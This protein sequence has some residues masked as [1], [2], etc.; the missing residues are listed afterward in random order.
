[1]PPPPRPPVLAYPPIT[2]L[3]PTQGYP[4]RNLRIPDPGYVTIRRRLV[5]ERRHLMKL[6]KGDR[7][8]G[9]VRSP[10]PRRERALRE[11]DARGELRHADEEE[12]QELLII[13]PRSIR[14]LI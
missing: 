4:L 9:E 14:K 12:L 10:C 11:G 7:E 3:P 2:S 8:K 1:M 6:D 13:A 5:V